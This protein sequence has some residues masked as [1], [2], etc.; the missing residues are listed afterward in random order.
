MSLPGLARA[1]TNVRTFAGVAVTALYQ[2][3]GFPLNHS[4]GLLVVGN[5]C[6]V[7]IF[8]SFD[9]VT[10][11]LCVTNGQSATF[12]FATTGALWPQGQVFVRG[13]GAG[14]AG[15]VVATFTGQL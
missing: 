8:L 15:N 3:M 2:P 10:D 12:P 5:T 1:Q 9:G 13:T 7:P 14:V 4:S 6:N 11:H